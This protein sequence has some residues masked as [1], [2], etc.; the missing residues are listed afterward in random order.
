MLFFFGQRQK[1]FQLADAFIVNKSPSFFVKCDADDRLKQC[2]V[3]SVAQKF[4]QY[5]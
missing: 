1:N 5:L 2:L 4:F 3:D